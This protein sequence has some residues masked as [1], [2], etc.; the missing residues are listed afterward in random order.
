LIQSFSST[1]AGEVIKFIRANVY[2]VKHVIEEEKIEAQGE[3]RRSFDVSLHE[4]DAI[5]V[6]TEFERQ[7]KSGFPLTEDLQYVGEQFAE[8]VSLDPAG[9]VA[10]KTGVIVPEMLKTTL[11]R[12]RQS[13]VQSVVL[14]PSS[15]HSSRTNS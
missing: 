12:L 7:L 5:E 2:A 10:L 8:R 13:A 4:E 9:I 6:K 1:A 11:C 14:A 3:L 15:C